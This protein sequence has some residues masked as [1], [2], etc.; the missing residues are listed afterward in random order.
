[1]L[2]KTNKPKA[3]KTKREKNKRES[4]LNIISLY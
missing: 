4:F 3:I 1:M 2:H